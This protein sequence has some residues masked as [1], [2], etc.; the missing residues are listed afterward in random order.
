M[1][2][3]DNNQNLVFAT[4]V[5]NS[6]LEAKVIVPC[7]TSPVRTFI[8]PP[9]KRLEMLASWR[10][11]RFVQALQA[12]N[13]AV[14]AHA[15]NVQNPHTILSQVLANSKQFSVVDLANTFCSISVHK[16]PQYWFAFSFK[17]KLRK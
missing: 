15:P 14:H 12:V 13:A 9:S 7:E 10:N 8:F 4:P 3:V 5:F 16:D 11:W 2:G 6:L 1:K 17:G